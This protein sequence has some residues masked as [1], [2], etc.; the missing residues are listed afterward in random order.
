MSDPVGTLQTVFE[1]APDCGGW[2][3]LA[4]VVQA[5]WDAIETQAPV[6]VKL[7]AIAKEAAVTPAMMTYY[8]ERRSELFAYVAAAALQALFHHVG[9]ATNLAELAGAWFEFAAQRP[10]AYHLA[11]DPAYAASDRVSFQRAGLA[12]CIAYVLR[13]SVPKPSPE[14]ASGV[15]AI[16]HGAASAMPSIPWTVSQLEAYLARARCSDS[17]AWSPSSSPPC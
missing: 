17:D 13:S 16:L 11:F 5:A 3:G 6:D 12:N 8:F 1:K 7:S 9:R 10:N 4:R 15:I 2:H 14:L